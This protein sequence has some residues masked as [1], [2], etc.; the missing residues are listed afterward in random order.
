KVSESVK[1]PDKILSSDAV[2]ALST[3]YFF[4]DAFDLPE[5][6]FELKHKLY[7]FRG[8]DVMK[9]IKS[10]DNN[11]ECVM[12]VGHNHA[13]T[14][15][16]NMLGNKHIENIPTCGFVA[17]EFDEKNWKDVATGKTA[18]TIFPRDLKK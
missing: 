12:L 17:I 15:L 2:R 8:A 3:A 14:S 18:L 9:V 10:L 1:A 4:K 13:F 7:D 16:V 5:E 11:L 6:D